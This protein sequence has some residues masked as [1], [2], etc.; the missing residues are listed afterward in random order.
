MTSIIEILPNLWIGHYHEC[1]NLLSFNECNIDTIINGCNRLPFTVGK[2]TK[3][4]I[5]VHPNDD[6]LTLID[7]INK[8]IDFIHCRLRKN[9]FI[10]LYSLKGDQID[11]T[12]M[13]CYLMK[14]RQMEPKNAIQAISSKRSNEFNNGLLF[15]TFLFTFYKTVHAT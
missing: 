10:L 3:Y 7:K 6:I 15:K 2:I 13:L 5:N 11:S 1:G 4:D 9:R 14:Y 12:I 8:V